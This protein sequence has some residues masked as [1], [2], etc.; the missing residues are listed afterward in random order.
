MLVSMFSKGHGDTVTRLLPLRDVLLELPNVAL[1][2]SRAI[3]LRAQDRTCLIVILD[4]LFKYLC[5]L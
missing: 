3:L 1:Q 4:F 2:V 5:Q